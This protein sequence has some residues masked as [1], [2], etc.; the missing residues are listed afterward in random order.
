M[1]IF[2]TYSSI[3]GQTI[4]LN[5]SQID[6]ELKQKP[7]KLCQSIEARWS[8]MALKLANYQLYEGRTMGTEGGVTLEV[9]GCGGRSWRG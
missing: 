6:S 5:L 8:L 1:L 4:D 9:G 2:G 3:I 7:N